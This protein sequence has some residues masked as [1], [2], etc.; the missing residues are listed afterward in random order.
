MINVDSLKVP[1]LEVKPFAIPPLLRSFFPP[2]FEEQVYHAAQL[3]IASLFPIHNVLSPDVTT[4]TSVESPL[5][6]PSHSKQERRPL[7]RSTLQI[8]QINVLNHKND[9]VT[10]HIERSLLKV[11]EYKVNEQK[12]KLMHQHF[13]ETARGQ[14]KMELIIERLAEQAH[15]EIKFT[16]DSLG[17]A[18]RDTF[19]A[20]TGLYI[21]KNG[22]SDMRKT[23]KITIDEVL[24]ACGKQR[25]NGSFKPEQR[26][27]VIK[28]IK[29]LS[30]S[31]INFSMPTTR[32]VKK[33]RTWIEED[34]EIKVEGYLLVYG[35]KIGE[36][37][38]ITGKEYWEFHDVTFGP[39]ADF[40]DGKVRTKLLPQQVL[41]YS[42]NNEPYH[43]KLGHYLHELFRT[44]ANRSK[45]VMPHGI[46]MRA[47]FEGACIEPHRDRGRF[48]DD[49][50]KALEH[51]KQD[52]VIGNYWYMLEKT[53]PQIRE[54]ITA[55]Q[56]RWF[57]DYLGLFIN[58]SPPEAT[59]NHYKN[60][61]K[62]EKEKI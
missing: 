61:A 29:T 10:H 62:K 23:F 15:E 9:H 20:L 34:T 13:I 60:I 57:D 24:D 52:E 30:Q 54:K 26:A 1:R 59:L 27:E 33:G 45:C 50:D 8:S 35:G 31:R 38:R 2:D 18:C 55:R 14:G 32:M 40:I 6:Q 7:Q 19:A 53:E 42:P 49:I 3:E 37:S 58:F 12:T 56:G 44:N 47:L 11:K 21:E 17:D 4:T 28:H 16:L 43:K 39:W 22:T 25:S 46:T 41:A 51:L 36:Y 5:E 48:K